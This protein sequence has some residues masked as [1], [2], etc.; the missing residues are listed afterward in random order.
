M[1][2]IARWLPVRTLRRRRTAQN[3]SAEIVTQ[4][5]DPARQALVVRQRDDHAAAGLDDAGGLAHESVR[6][7]EVVERALAEDAVEAVVPERQRLGDAAHQRH[8]ARRHNEPAQ[9]Q[10]LCRRLQPPGLAAV[11]GDPRRQLAG[12]TGDVQRHTTRGRRFVEK[13]LL[14]APEQEVAVR[15]MHGGK[16]VE[17]VA[18]I[19]R[20]LSRRTSL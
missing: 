1:V 8:A 5:A 19:D 3:G 7:G 2:V 17:R 10:H 6:L 13:R 4:T 16:A 18:E 11:G 20:R 12:A 14:D 15:M 9:F